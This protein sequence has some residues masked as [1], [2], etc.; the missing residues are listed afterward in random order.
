MKKLFDAITDL[1]SNTSPD[2][3]PQL[4][5]SLRSF[6]GAHAFGD[7]QKWAQ[8]VAAKKYL[9]QLIDCWEKHELPSLEL[10][11]MLL[12]ASHAYHAAKSEQDLELVWTGPSSELIATRK[13]EQVLLEVIK[14]AKNKLFLTSFVAYD[15]ASIVTSL[16]NAAERGVNLSLLLESSDKYGGSV[17]IDAITQMRESLPAAKIY[18]WGNKGEAFVGGK[19]H[20]KVAVCD[21]KL[22]F[23]S[24]ANLTGHAMEKNM[25][26]GILIRGGTLPR[27]VHNHLEALVTIKIVQA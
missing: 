2:K 25:E 5:E 14:A 6:G 12:G 19:V 22:C 8:T 11:G 4:A 17:S 13:T 10:A 15:V 3:I 9:D 24:S 23:I 7:L 21:E 26:A 1:V 16:A 27:T 18:F 20:A